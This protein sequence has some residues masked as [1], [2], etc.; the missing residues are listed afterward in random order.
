MSGLREEQKISM[1]GLREEQKMAL[2]KR[3]NGLLPPSP[4]TPA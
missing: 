2:Q 4:G 3:L 1:S